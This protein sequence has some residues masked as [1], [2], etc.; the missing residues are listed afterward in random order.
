[1]AI[2]RGFSALE[3]EIALKMISSSYSDQLRLQ[4][5]TQQFQRPKATN[6]QVRCCPRPSTRQPST[7][8]FGN[9]LSMGYFAIPHPS[10][11]DSALPF[12]GTSQR[13]T[14]ARTW[15]LSGCMRRAVAMTVSNPH[16][17]CRDLDPP[18]RA[19]HAHRLREV[20]HV[21]GCPPLLARLLRSARRMP[22]S[23]IDRGRKS[24][25]ARRSPR[26]PRLQARRRRQVA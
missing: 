11:R 6:S 1:M 15:T 14:S 20:I 24:G 22:V 2:R 5:R 17:Y 26:L 4:A 13:P 3:S 16:L 18:L 8:G 12:Q 7:A 25:A 19:P 9:A 23:R 21:H 10:A